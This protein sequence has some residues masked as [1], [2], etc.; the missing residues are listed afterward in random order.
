MFLE[1][2]TRPAG[3]KAIILPG[4]FG[5]W[6]QSASEHRGFIKLGSCTVTCLLACFPY[7]TRAPNPSSS[8]TLLAMEVRYMSH[9][10]LFQA[11]APTFAFEG[12]GGL[13]GL[14][15]SPST[16]RISKEKE[17]SCLPQS[18]PA[19][20]DLLGGMQGR[21]RDAGSNQRKTSS[22]SDQVIA[23]T[24]Q[25][26]NM[27]D[28]SISHHPRPPSRTTVSGLHTGYSLPH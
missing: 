25:S 26:Q 11:A 2:H 9:T 21:R 17:K 23:T 1:S 7:T 4:C 8:P 22:D 3:R 13:G 5:I 20:Y 6:T 18:T 16:P 10:F 27:T 24:T 12:G 14:H 28:Q 15:I 19:N